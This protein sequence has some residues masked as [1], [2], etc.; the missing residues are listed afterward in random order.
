[1]SGRSVVTIERHIIEEE[2]R[3]PEASGAFGNILYD[4]AL[5]AKLISREV[6]RAGLIDILGETGSIN[7]PRAHRTVSRIAGVRAGRGAFSCRHD[8]HLLSARK[9]S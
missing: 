5:A 7:K 2:R 6:R 1:M 8:G 4:L 9:T 3:L